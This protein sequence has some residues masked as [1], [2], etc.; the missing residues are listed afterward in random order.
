MA[1]ETPSPVRAEQPVQ[2][3]R[4]GRRPRAT[5]AAKKTRRSLPAAS[6]KPANVL[7]CRLKPSVLPSAELFTRS[8][9]EDHREGERQHREEDVAVARQQQAED[10]GDGRRGS[11][12]AS[13]ISAA[14]ARPPQCPEQRGG[15]G[16]EAEVEALAERHEPGAHQQQEPEHDDALGEREREQENQPL[17]RDQAAASA[18]H[19]ERP[20]GR[21]VVRSAAHI[22]R[23]SGRREQA[24]RPRDQHQRHDGVDRE[25][26][27]LRPVAHGRRA[28]HAD[29][30]RAERRA[31]E[32]AEPADH[33]HREREHDHLDADA[34][35]DR[36]GRRGQRAAERRRASRRS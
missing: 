9:V 12:P 23:A 1:A 18:A 26:L 32:A 31:A 16:A 17:R 8:A 11:V 29:Q 19:A 21:R 13:S 15:V 6:A 24:L 28:H 4:R 10:G 25:Q 36:D 27:G 22:L 20:R 7:A 2:E 5:P 34:G 33:D 14:S 3:P 30:Q 35:P